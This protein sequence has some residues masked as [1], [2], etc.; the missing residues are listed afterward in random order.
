M[1]Q[2]TANP[3]MTSYATNYTKIKLTDNKWKSL[4]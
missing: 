1:H 3:Q 2:M 4:W